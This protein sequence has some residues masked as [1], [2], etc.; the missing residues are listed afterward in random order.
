LST[1]RHPIDP[2]SAVPVFG[3]IP[4]WTLSGVLPP[5]LGDPTSSINMAPYP[6]TLQYVVE[7][8]ATTP[9]RTEILQGL[10]TYRRAL[11]KQGISNGFQWLNGSILEDIEKIESR[12]PND[13]DIVT[14]FRRP[15]GARD[16]IAWT[17]FFAINRNLFSPIANKAAFKCDTQYI[18][19][20][21]TAEDVV[22]LTRFWFGL[23]SH[24][25]NDV[26]KGMLTIS[27]AISEDDDLAQT[28]IERMKTPAVDPVRGSTP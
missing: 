22:S 7:R 2:S 28:L 13:I 15:I 21:S 1:P 8:F 26:W 25:R 18:D 11:S 27:L 12:D 10:L 23:F 14:F 17:H 3:K 19:L 6:T 9:R 4:A 16:P 24:R 20:D 5:Y